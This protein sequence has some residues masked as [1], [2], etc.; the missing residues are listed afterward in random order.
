MAI[1]R[2]IPGVIRLR[3]SPGLNARPGSGVPIVTNSALIH[4]TAVGVTGA[5][6]Q[7]AADQAAISLCSTT[8]QIFAAKSEIVQKADSA[9]RYSFFHDR[10][11]YQSAL[12]RLI[13]RQF[14]RSQTAF[15]PVR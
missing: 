3:V 7:R 4:I 2:T 6:A 14:Q 5:D 10:T 1:I 15:S 12:Q 11:R 9:R 8:R 13:A